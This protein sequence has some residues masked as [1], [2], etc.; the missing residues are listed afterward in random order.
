MPNTPDVIVRQRH[1]H[2]LANPQL[3]WVKQL[4]LRGL[5]VPGKS[6]QTQQP[7]LLSLGRGLIAPQELPAALSCSQRQTLLR[8]QEEAEVMRVQTLPV[9]RQ[10]HQQ[11]V[12]IR[13]GAKLA[14]RLLELLACHMGGQLLLAAL[15]L[16]ETQ[17]YLLERKETLHERE[18]SQVGQKVDH[19][20][21]EFTALERKGSELISSPTLCLV[22]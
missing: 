4:A 2:V 19:C 17:T 16:L 15:D 20:G 13:P 22:H 21:G 6:I 1:V 8:L 14:V 5:Q 11:E 7:P 9:L 3:L 18:E 12:H 10:L